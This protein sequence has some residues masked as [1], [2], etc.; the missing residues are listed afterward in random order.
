M[1]TNLMMAKQIFCNMTLQ[2][3]SISAIQFNLSNDNLQKSN[4]K[5]NAHRSS[6]KSA[7]NSVK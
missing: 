7:D 6:S 3:S 4:E 2:A 1:Q 5:R